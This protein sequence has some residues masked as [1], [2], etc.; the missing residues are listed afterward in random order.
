[1]ITDPSKYEQLAEE[2]MEAVNSLMKSN[3]SPDF[4][5]VIYIQERVDILEAVA[6]A[7]KPTEL[8]P[9]KTNTADKKDL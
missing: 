5:D 3:Q 7:K 9:R 4:E 1:M 8:S 6:R 2:I